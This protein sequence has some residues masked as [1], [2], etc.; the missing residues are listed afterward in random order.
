MA[1]MAPELI[2]SRVCNLGLVLGSVTNDEE[3]QLLG[4]TIAN[5]PSGLS[6]GSAW[7]LGLNDFASEGI[8]EW[9]DGTPCIGIGGDDITNT[10][11]IINGVHKNSVIYTLGHLAPMIMQNVVGFIG[12]IFSRTT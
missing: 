8:W 12:Q 7:L 6:V 9:E 11:P 5:H 3:V 2:M 4:K 1:V 10:Y